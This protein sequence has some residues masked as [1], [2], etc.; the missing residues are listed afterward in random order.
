MR[1]KT[2]G[3]RD[4]LTEKQNRENS[5]K[6]ISK[7][8]FIIACEY[9]IRVSIN[10]YYPCSCFSKLFSVYY[11]IRKYNMRVLLWV[12]REQSKSNYTIKSIRFLFHFFF[13]G[14]TKTK[15]NNFYFYVN[16]VVPKFWRGCKI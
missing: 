8:K 12:F 4:Y 15:K 9:I 1:D 7:T 5:N 16:V 6:K 13:L 10:I 11:S 2:F 3:R 14:K